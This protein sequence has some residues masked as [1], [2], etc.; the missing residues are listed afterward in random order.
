MSTEQKVVVITGAGQ[1]IGRELANQ[2]A[3]AGTHV[4]VVDIAAEKAQATTEWIDA[5]WP[6]SATS[7]AVDVTDAGRVAELFDTVARTRGRIDVLVNN[8]VTETYEPFL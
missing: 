1:G 7:A 3:G 4:I 8:A 6:G 2:F 5:E